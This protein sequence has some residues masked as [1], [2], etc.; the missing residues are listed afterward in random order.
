MSKLKKDDKVVRTGRDSGGVKQGHVYVVR[1][2]YSTSIKLVGVTGEYYDY[3][4]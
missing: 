3:N 4:K 1:E 2:V